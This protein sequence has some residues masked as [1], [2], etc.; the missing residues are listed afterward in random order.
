MVKPM[1]AGGPQQM[2]SMAG[3]PMGSFQ[4]QNGLTPQQIQQMQAQMQNQR[5]MMF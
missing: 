4:A 3:N 2:P 5:S 1:A